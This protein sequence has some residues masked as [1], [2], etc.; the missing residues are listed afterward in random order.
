MYTSSEVTEITGIAQDVM[1]D[2]RRRG[3]SYFGKQLENGRYVYSSVDLIGLVVSEVA[4]RNIK[5]LL[6]CDR[7]GRHMARLLAMHLELGEFIDPP[8]R[9]WIGHGEVFGKQTNYMLFAEGEDPLYTGNA[10]LVS[11]MEA[12][13]VHVFDAR[14]LV[15]RLP[16]KLL[17]TLKI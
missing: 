2:R 5:S 16:A 11:D 13:L 10:S 9:N 4:S 6:E 17:E 1:R 7:A 14:K 12:T 15:K 3:I 8:M